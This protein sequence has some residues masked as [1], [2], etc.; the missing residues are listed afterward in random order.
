MDFLTR[1]VVRYSAKRGEI[2][3]REEEERREHLQPQRRR[4]S[5]GRAY[6][7]LMRGRRDTEAYE[8]YDGDDG[9]DYNDGYEEAEPS[10]EYPRRHAVWD[11]EDG[12]DGE[13]DDGAERGFGYGKR[14]TAAVRRAEATGRAP[15]GY[16]S[17]GAADADSAE[18]ETAYG[19]TGSGRSG[20]EA[21]RRR[22]E[23]GS[24]R[25]PSGQR[26]A[27]RGSRKK[28]RPFLRILLILVVL[29]L[30]ITAGKMLLTGR[31]WTIAVFGVDS[32]N[33]A[34]EKGTRSDVI[35]LVNVDRKTGEIKLA[36]V[37]RDTYLKLNS[38][39][40]YGKINA[41]Y[42]K[43]GHKQA[44][45]A[46]SENLDV[47]IDDYIT[48]N[49][50]AVAKGINELGGVDL[51]ISKPEFAYI[52]AFITET[53]N[54]TGIGSTQLS[55]PGMNHLD[56]V[57]AVAY[58]RLR[59]MDTDFNRTAR[60]RKVIGLAMEKAKAADPATLT[61]LAAALLPEVSTSIG[62][63]D[64]GP[65]LKN[66][67]RYH[68]TETGGFPYSLKTEKIGKQ[69]CVIPT[70]LESNVLQ[71]HQ[72]FFGE[73]AYSV[74]SSVKKISERIG[75][76]SGYTEPGQQAP[77]FGTGGASGTSSGN[78]AAAAPQQTAAQE[79]LPETELSEPETES[80]E[81]TELAPEETA[82]NFPEESETAETQETERAGHGKTPEE[83]QKDTDREST[84]AETKESRPQIADAPQE[85][86]SGANLPPKT[87]AAGPG[88]FVQ[89]T[90]EVGPGVS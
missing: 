83:T 1:K 50:A 5:S 25:H 52:N 14:R 89:E 66:I 23:T 4:R 36:S 29:V 62:L 38:D 37:Y 54:S 27:S 47:Q 69:D 74:P 33:G 42:E 12:Y 79:T 64:L 17:F 16:G 57:Q 55:S 56:G 28:R 85:V 10:G 41:A 3:R 53:V 78:G 71:L 51:E 84:A 32:R 67:S 35:M 77:A 82:E 9:S 24:G 68:I 63:D 75:S 86:G 20:A 72:E 44:I 13:T 76:D 8:T 46:L 73:S 65:I 34:S 21:R 6:A 18:F 58:G 81:E 26:A 2:M 19:R 11:E 39:G 31:N 43:G 15:G 40:D 30:G 7:E 48:F 90:E 70:T 60:Q 80:E 88:A 59:L 45:R 87:S 61:R 49:W 22:T